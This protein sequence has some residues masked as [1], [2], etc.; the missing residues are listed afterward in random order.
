MPGTVLSHGERHGTMTARS[1]QW[2]LNSRGGEDRRPGRSV[3]PP[4]VFALAR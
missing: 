1:G 2:A 3:V 4:H